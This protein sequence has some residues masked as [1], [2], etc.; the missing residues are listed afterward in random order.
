MIIDGGKGFCS[1]YYLHICIVNTGFKACPSGGAASW[2][3][4]GLI[5][6]LVM[7][8][9]GQLPDYRLGADRI[10]PRH[11]QR[12]RTEPATR[13]NTTKPH[14]YYTSHPHTPAQR[15]HLSFPCPSEPLQPVAL[16]HTH[17]CHQNGTSQNTL[18]SNPAPDQE[19]C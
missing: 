1:Y 13:Q 18:L 5:V 12:D 9:Y 19:L 2:G 10:K 4:S 15:D 11:R 6:S 14:D 16:L 8:P 3:V 7:H 17:L